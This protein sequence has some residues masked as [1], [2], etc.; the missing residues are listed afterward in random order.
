M[1]GLQTTTSHLDADNRL[2]ISQTRSMVNLMCVVNATNKMVR[3][4][5][6]KMLAT[7]I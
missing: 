3:S 2:L 7:W 4:N 6:M 1:H 5:L